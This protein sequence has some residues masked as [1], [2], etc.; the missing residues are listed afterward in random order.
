MQNDDNIIFIWLIFN[1]AARPYNNRKKSGYNIMIIFFNFTK[2]CIQTHFFLQKWTREGY[3]K[4]Y[5][6]NLIVVLP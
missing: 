2:L 6:L 3:K 5:A 4:L 1:S